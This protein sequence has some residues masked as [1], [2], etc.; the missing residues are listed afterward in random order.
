[1]VH[2]IVTKFLCLLI[3]MGS[4]TSQAPSAS[5]YQRAKNAITDMVDGNQ[6]LPRV[7]RLGMLVMIIIYTA[8]NTIGLISIQY[9]WETSL[10]VSAFHD[11]VGPNGCDGCINDDHPENDGLQGTKNR[12]QNL[13]S[14]HGFQ[15]RKKNDHLQNNKCWRL[16]ITL[17]ILDSLYFFL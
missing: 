4:V 2:N 6:D 7:V 11:C 8:N 10:N 9:H 5:E 12:L 13:R 1:M 14:S 17:M 16:F 15:V 3:W